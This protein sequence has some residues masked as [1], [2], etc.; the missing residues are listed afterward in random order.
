MYKS[1]SVAATLSLKLAER[2]TEEPAT[3]VSG[4]IA[5]T[6]GGV[7]SAGGVV[8]VIVAVGLWRYVPLFSRHE[9]NMVCEP[10]EEKA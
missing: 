7:A 3:A 8:T 10:A 4:E 2:T 9:T 5:P 6:T 1:H